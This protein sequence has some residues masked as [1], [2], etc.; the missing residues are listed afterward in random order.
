MSNPQLALLQGLLRR[1]GSI[2]NSPVDG[3]KIVFF[4]KF[5]NLGRGVGCVAPA[6]ADALYPGGEVGCEKQAGEANIKSVC[7]VTDRMS[8]RIA[9]K[10]RV[11]HD[12]MSLGKYSSG[13]LRHQFI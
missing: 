9:G 5:G 1:P 12:G 11:D 3:A 6:A 4:L 7:D 2:D 10:Y 13:A 8:F